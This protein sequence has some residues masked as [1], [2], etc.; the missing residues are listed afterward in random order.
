MD[1]TTLKVGHALVKGFTEERT[2]ETIEL[3][4]GIAVH[5]LEKVPGLEGNES[6]EQLLLVDL[7]LE[8]HELEESLDIEDVANQG[9]E[10][11]K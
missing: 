5:V 8:R 7:V 6:S 2:N 1:L 10:F 3:V 9:S 4:I 11:E